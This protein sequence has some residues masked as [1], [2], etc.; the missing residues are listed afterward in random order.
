MEGLTRSNATVS[1]GDFIDDEAL[2][3]GSMSCSEEASFSESP[4]TPPT[5]YS[6]LPLWMKLEQDED[7]GDYD[8]AH[9]LDDICDLRSFAL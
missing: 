8:L 1:L 2:E 7:A 9:E 5:S 6:K 4:R 3:Q